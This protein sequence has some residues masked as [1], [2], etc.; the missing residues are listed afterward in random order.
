MA[1]LLPVNFDGDQ[2]LTCQHNGEP[3]VAMRRIV[4]NLGLDWGGQR[5]RL[6]DEP[7][8]MCGLMST[9]DSSGRLQEMLVMPVGKLALWLATINANK[10]RPDLKAKIEAYQE[11]C[12]VVLHDYWTQ[13]VAVRDDLAGVVTDLDPAVMKALGGMFKAILLKTVHEVIP[14]MVQAEI[15][16][17]QYSV[18]RGLTAGQVIELAGVTDR[19]NTRGVP[20]RVSDRLR[21]FC[22]EKGRAVSIAH[23]GRSSA[24]VFDALTVREWLDEVGRSLIQGWVNERRGTNQLRL[25]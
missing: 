15:G 14:Q 11:R 22:A 23:L 6:V 12:A 13:G 25:V 5:R 16:A 21:R 20:R 2:I 4:E 8:F 7:K 18:T 3:V 19:K 24:Y 1:Q 10:V 17:Q 9:H